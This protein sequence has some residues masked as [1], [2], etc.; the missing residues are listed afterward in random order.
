MAIISTVSRETQKN[1]TTEEKK[2][3]DIAI[4]YYKAL[5]LWKPG[6]VL[7]HIDPSLKLRD[8]QRYRNWNVEDLV[9]VTVQQH[10]RIHMGMKNPKGVKKSADH[11]R[12]MVSGH[13]KE[14]RSCNILISRVILDE[15]GNEGI[16]TYVFPTC[17]AAARHIGCTLQLV[18]QVASKTQHNRRA[19]GW[20]CNYVPKT[21]SLG[22]VEEEVLK[23]L[24]A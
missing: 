10:M 8:P 5:G 2:K 20:S 23:N 11:L 19:M 22:K 6:M 16:E 24:V 13:R 14:R 17:A 1:M 3:H 18:Y 12:A 4:E 15:N 9:P 7:H 21:V